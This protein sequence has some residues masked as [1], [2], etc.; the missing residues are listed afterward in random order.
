MTKESIKQIY[1]DAPTEHLH[2]SLLK[3]VEQWSEQPSSLQVLRLLANLQ[4]K[5]SAFTLEYTQ[6]LFNK[7]CQD[8]GRHPEEVAAEYQKELQNP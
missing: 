7:C 4:G 6:R 2:P 5:A 8:D 1:L 3:Y